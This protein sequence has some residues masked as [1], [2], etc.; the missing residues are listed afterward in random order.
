MMEIRKRDKLEKFVKIMQQIPLIAMVKVK[1]CFQNL[2]KLGLTVALR[3][4]CA[5]SL[6]KAQIISTS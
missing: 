4:S 3:T 5:W 2:L 6:K 1:K